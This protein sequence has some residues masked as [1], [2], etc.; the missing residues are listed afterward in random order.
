MA[1]SFDNSPVTN[2]IGG[3]GGNG[4]VTSITAGTGLTGGTITTS[5]TLARETLSPSPAGTYTKSS[6]TVDSSGRVTA[7]SNGAADQLVVQLGSSSF[8]QYST[9]TLPMTGA[10]SGTVFTDIGYHS[11][12]VTRGNDP[13]TA[14]AQSKWGY[15]SGYFYDDYLT[16]SSTGG[17]FAMGTSDFT[18]ETWIYMLE[19]PSFGDS[20]FYTI[21]FDTRGAGYGFVCGISSTYTLTAYDGGTA[22]VSTNS[23]SSPLNN[24]HHLCWMR[25]N[26]LLYY[27]IDGVVDPT[28]SSLTN[29]FNSDV[30]TVGMS[31]ERSPSYP[32]VRGYLNDFRFSNGLARYSTSGFS[33]PTGPV[34]AARIYD[35]PASPS[36]GQMA[37]GANDLFVCTNASG[38]IWK[39]VSI[40]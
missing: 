28:V 23:I 26:N 2:N 37:L 29:N 32:R 22:Y 27:F 15:G 13:V 5:G 21:L 12:T 7:A 36:V 40:S 10:N 6:L 17:H 33:A 9:L 18:I 1:I 34:A 19:N 8:D 39:K 31:M 24:W 4:T 38:P 30:C 11:L 14:T 25:K 20:R 35:L 16:V 3:G